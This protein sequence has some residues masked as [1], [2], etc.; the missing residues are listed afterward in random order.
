METKIRGSKMKLTRFVA[1]AALIGILV[2]CNRTTPIVPVFPTTG[3]MGYSGGVG[4]G[5]GYNTYTATMPSQYGLNSNFLC[6]N[7]TQATTAPLGAQLTSVYASGT[8][9]FPDLYGQY[10]TN[11]GMQNQYVFSVTSSTQGVFS[12]IDS[13]I[14]LQLTG[15]AMLPNYIYNPTLGGQSQSTITLSVGAMASCNAYLTSTSGIN[16][17]VGC[18][19]ISLSNYPQNVMQYYAQ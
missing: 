14:S 18:V 8:F 2:G 16:K 7:I 15:M 17:I 3:T 9:S 12:A 5:T 10:T 19:L 1:I 13:S 6:L 11:Q 4:C